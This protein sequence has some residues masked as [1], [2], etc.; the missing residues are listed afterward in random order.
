MSGSGRLMTFARALAD[1]EL[2]GATDLAARER[3]L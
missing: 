2:G 1:V 3:G